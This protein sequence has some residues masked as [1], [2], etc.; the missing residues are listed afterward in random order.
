LHGIEKLGFLTLTFEDEDSDVAYDMKEAMSRF[1]SLSTNIISPRYVKAIRA[2]ERSPIGRIHFHLV[3]VLSHDIRTGFNFDEV[4]NKSLP[5]HLRYKSACPYLRSEWSF[6]R[7]IAPQYG[8]GR[9]EL[10]PIRSTA[11]AIARYVG[12]YIS[13]HVGQRISEDKGAR[14]VS[15]IGYKPGER[16]ASTRFS[17]NSP[18]S[19]V[20]RKKVAAFCSAYKTDLDTLKEMFGGQWAYYL[21]ETILDMP[22]DNITYPTIE[23]AKIAGEPGMEFIPS[24]A[25]DIKIPDRGLGQIQIDSEAYDK[26]PLWVP[27]AP[28]PSEFSAK[29]QVIKAGLHAIYE[30][31]DQHDRAVK[32]FQVYVAAMRLEDKISKIM[33]N[34]TKQGPERR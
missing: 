24:G 7:K 28:D 15:Y 25:T 12:G 3:V 21:Q 9:T 1:H 4:K 34:S 29:K 16:T 22:L 18:R 27:N 8:F 2:V 13:K 26:D 10:M 30:M 14:L 19:W 33:E 31:Q 20:W 5:R 11:E 23:H 17:Y 6:L 32:S